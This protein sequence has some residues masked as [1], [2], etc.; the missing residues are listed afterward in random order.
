MK[1]PF[2]K[3]RSKHGSSKTYESFSELK[4]LIDE[5]YERF[6]DAPHRRKMKPG[7]VSFGYF[8]FSGDAK[9]EKEYN[10]PIDLT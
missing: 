8:D 3:K 10:E 9:D 2:G 5:G 4:K 7:K 1:Q 6:W